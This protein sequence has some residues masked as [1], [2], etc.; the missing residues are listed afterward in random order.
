MPRL[1]GDD[2][3]V[4]VIDRKSQDQ[5]HFL[6]KGAE[7]RPFRSSGGGISGPCD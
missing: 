5:C 7:K 6:W 1:R 4:T 3:W 2:E